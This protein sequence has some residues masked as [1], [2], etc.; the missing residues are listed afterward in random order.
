[1][2]APRSLCMRKTNANAPCG[3]LPRVKTN[4]NVLRDVHNHHRRH[5]H[6]IHLVILH[7]YASKNKKKGKM[8]NAQISKIRQRHQRLHSYPA[9]LRHEFNNGHPQRSRTAKIESRK[10]TVVA[11]SAADFR[12][13]S[14][15]RR[16]LQDSM[17]LSSNLRSDRLT[18]FILEH[19]RNSRPARM[20]ILIERLN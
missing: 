11:K 2:S 19:L 12:S 13:E 16:R 20:I 1:M 8:A 10:S 7:V 15:S 18:S 14:Q 9:L 4:A 3:T 17:A 6:E 5:H